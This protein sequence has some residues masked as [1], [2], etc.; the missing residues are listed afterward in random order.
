M[1]SYDASHLEHETLL[2][3]VTST[4]G[5]GDAPENGEIFA[6]QLQAIKLTGDTIPDLESV[7]L[8]QIH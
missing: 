7:R 2:L 8:V 5:N 1:D 6:K 3:I 4:F